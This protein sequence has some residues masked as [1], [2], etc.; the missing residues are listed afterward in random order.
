LCG[1]CAGGAESLVERYGGGDPA[2]A[3]VNEASLPT[4]SRRIFAPLARGAAYVLIALTFFVIVTLFSS[5][6]R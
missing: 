5:V 1:G 4:T 3:L 6:I 2:I